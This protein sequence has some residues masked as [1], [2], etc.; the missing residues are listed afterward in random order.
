MTADRAV[1]VPL[2]YVLLLATIAVLSATLFV[3]MGDFVQA[4]RTD[5]VE[6]TLDVI[7]H[8]LS[9]DIA[10]ADRLAGPLQGAGN[11]TVA[12]DLP[13]QVAGSTYTVRVASIGGNRSH[14]VLETIRPSTTVTVD[15]VTERALAPGTVSGGPVTVVYNPAVDRLEVHH[16]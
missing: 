12:V 4:E 11:L 3:G 16:A 1:S 2:Q 14:L 8:R 15:I 5:A 6:G 7:G 9:A 13:T 10:T